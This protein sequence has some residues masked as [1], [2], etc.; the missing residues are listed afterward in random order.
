MSGTYPLSHNVGRIHGRALLDGKII[1]IPDVVADPDYAWEQAQR[2]GGFRTILGVPMLRENIP[3]GVLTL[4]R[5]E[6]RPFTDKQIELVT[7]FADQAAIAIENV[8]LFEEEATARAAAEAARDAAERARAEA[9]AAR[10]DVER[11]RDLAEGARREAEAANQAKSTFLA[12]MSHEIRTPMNGVLGMI[13]V[14][15]RQGLSAPQQRSTFRPYEI[16]ARRCCASSM[17]CS[18]SPRSRPAVSNSRPHTFSLTGLI[19]GDAGHF[20]AAGDRQEACPRCRNRSGLAGRSD[21][22]SDPR[23][24]NPVQPAQQCDQIHRTW[25]RAGARQHDA[26]R[27]QAIHAQQSL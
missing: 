18:T 5:S 20:P 12:T 7:T 11:T 23:A 24:A 13:E 14:L 10:A 17:T 4:A 26:A 8:R 16:L 15:E 6:V 1:H 2:L 27:R 21:R 25:R 19:D 22:R 3:I 9:A